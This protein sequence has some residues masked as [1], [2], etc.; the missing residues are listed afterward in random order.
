MKLDAILTFSAIMQKM[1]G[2]LT[3]TRRLGLVGPVNKDRWVAVWQFSDRAGTVYH[4][5]RLVTLVTGIKERP[6]CGGA[7]HVLEVPR[8]FE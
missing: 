1:L 6:G 8:N 3:S 4:D 2:T 5:R 7:G